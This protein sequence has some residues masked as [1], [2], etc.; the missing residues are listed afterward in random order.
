MPRFVVL[1]HDGPR[2]LHWD[3]MLEMGQGLATWALDRAPDAAGPIPA[4]ALPEHRLAYLDF[5]GPLSGDRGAVSRWDRGS[6]ELRIQTDSEVIAALCGEK[7]EGQAALRC[8]AAGR[9]EF[10]FLPR[11]KPLTTT[12]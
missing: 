6:C 8:S 5:E 12:G 9:W 2:G 4:K 10:S 7:L 3:F 11:L 1:R